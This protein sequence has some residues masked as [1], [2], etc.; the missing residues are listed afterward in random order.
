VTG[1][2]ASGSER[3]LWLQAVRGLVADARSERALLPMDSAE[4]QFYLGVE[5]AAEEVLQPQ[6]TAAREEHWLERQLS[7]Y[8]DGYVRTADLLARLSTAPEPPLRIPLPQPPP[9][10]SR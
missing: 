2:A 1:G 3:P 7:A 9:P 6:L 5:K 4:R 8:R 10:G